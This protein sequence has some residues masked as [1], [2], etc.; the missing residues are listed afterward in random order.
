[1]KMLM[2]YLIFSGC[3][4]DK[5]QTESS[6]QDL[7]Q[8]GFSVEEGDCQDEDADI[9]PE[10]SDLVGDDIDSNCD[11]IDGVD[12]DGDGYASK[13]SGG[14]DCDDNDA[15][16][17]PGLVE[18]GADE[19]CLWDADGDGY[20]AI[21][22]PEGFDVGT[23]CNDT[24]PSE[25]P[26]AV[27]H[28]NSN[29]CCL[30]SD[31]DGY[32][33]QNAPEP[34]DYGFDCD[35]TDP[36]IYPGAVEEAI[37]WGCMLDMDGD[38][39]GDDDPP[40]GF[41]AG[42]DCNDSDPGT[43]DDRDC[44]GLT[45]ANDCDDFDPDWGDKSTDQDCDRFTVD[46]DCDDNDW[47]NR[48]MLDMDSDG[49]AEACVLFSHGENPFSFCVAQAGEPARCKSLGEHQS[50]ANAPDIA[51]EHLSVGGETACG[52]DS[53]GTLHCWGSDEWGIVS[54]APDGEWKDI[55]LSYSGACALS[56][57]G[58]P[59]CWGAADE[60]SYGLEPVLEG[61][62]LQ[63]E[64]SDAAQ[65]ACGIK[66]D[67]TIDCWSSALSPNSSLISD[68]PEG[69]F[70]RLAMG[71]TNACA[72]DEDGKTTCWGTDSYGLV[73][74]HPSTSFV[75]IA[76]SEKRACGLQSNGELSCWGSD[77]ETTEGTWAAVSTARSQ[78][79]FLE[80]N[81]NVQCR[82]LEDMYLTPTPVGTFETVDVARV[83]GCAVDSDGYMQCW[84]LLGSENIEPLTVPLDKWEMAEECLVGLVASDHTD[85]G[86]V[87]HY[88]E[89][90][91]YGV[92][93]TGNNY[94]DVAAGAWHGCALDDL[95]QIDCW[96]ATFYY[97]DDGQ[98]S[99]A[100]SGSGYTDISAGKYFSCAA[101]DN[102][103]V[104]IW[105]WGDTGGIFSPYWDMPMVS[106]IEANATNS[107]YCYI[108]T[109]GIIE[110]SDCYTS[111]FCQPPGGYWEQIDLANG[112]CARSADN[113]VQ[114]WGLQPDPL[115]QHN[116]IDI[117]VGEGAA[118]GITEDG[119]IECWGNHMKLFMAGTY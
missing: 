25:Y 82:Y 34:Y 117:G 32:G 91:Y 115:F 10:S 80:H 106:S 52:I 44:D 22:P 100:P 104:G 24:D 116:Y 45:Y 98:A 43:P 71:K 108:K 8:D 67:H 87:F 110:C 36:N 63:V 65:A 56:L 105:C 17:I 90:D 42:T 66:T 33:D 92:A 113:Q 107:S 12:Q 59:T 114:C 84:G 68:F 6:T 28:E 58:I 88:G 70:Y 73:S 79:C 103:S 40:D 61:P 96:G 86:T 13:E 85:A 60:A 27:I 38:G 53:T 48:P 3:V 83:S 31:G 64:I 50:I 54:G 21:S 74:N 20:G 49:L 72:L 47:F 81:G 94:V 23:D 89:C 62:F 26:G 2:T 15:E 41:E 5:S 97:I 102:P 39:L 9:N 93:P 18:E 57:D 76:L 30:D 77:I 35:D 7:D 4:N 14:L 46:V 1:M 37:P 78:Q 69:A 55:S 111:S 29:K 101:S 118:C 11:G 99:D 109:N 51:L 19:E 75:S 119:L 112:G 95:G 16:H